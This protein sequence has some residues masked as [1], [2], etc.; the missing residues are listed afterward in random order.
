M[1]VA[2]RAFAFA[3]LCDLPAGTPVV[4]LVR[5]LE[6]GMVHRMANPGEEVS[7]LKWML[8]YAANLLKPPARYTV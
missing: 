4:Q 2:E 6:P 7:S 1:D 5:D 3:S 8:G